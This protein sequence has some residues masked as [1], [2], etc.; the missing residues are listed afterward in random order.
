LI[1]N[2]AKLLFFKKNIKKFKSSRLIYIKKLYF[3]SI[4][5]KF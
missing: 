5:P 1:K 3:L 4:F 2:C